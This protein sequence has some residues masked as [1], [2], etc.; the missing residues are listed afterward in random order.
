[1]KPAR[2]SLIMTRF[3][4]TMVACGALACH[5]PQD[6]AARQAA[7]RA[8]N[9]NIPAVIQ[10]PPPVLPSD[11]HHVVP[12]PAPSTPKEMLQVLGSNYAILGLA[13]VS[14]DRRMIGATYAPDAELTTPDTT[15]H[16]AVAIAQSMGQMGP[17]NSLREFRRTPRAT[18]VQDSTVT[19]SGAYVI[20][21]KRAGA[22]SLVERG[23]YATVWRARA[24]GKNWVILTDH[25]S[26]M[27]G[28]RKKKS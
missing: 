14:G 28:T 5:A 11:T 27:S 16:G 25:I 17:R 22:D 23:T 1:M 13:I 9:P 3:C 18:N 6:Q 26:H 21:S 4:I 20:L 24:G 2:D 10:V 12:A 15:L 19:D 7:Q 8:A